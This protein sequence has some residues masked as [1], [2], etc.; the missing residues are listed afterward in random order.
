MAPSPTRRRTTP[1]LRSPRPHR[2]PGEKPSLRSPPRSHPPPDRRYTEEGTRSSTR[3]QGPRSRWSPLSALRGAAKYTKERRTRFP[4]VLRGASLLRDFAR[5]EEVG[6]ARPMGTR[7]LPGIAFDP[8]GLMAAGDVL[9]RTGAGHLYCTATAAIP[10]SSRQ[11]TVGGGSRPWPVCCGIG[12]RTLPEVVPRLSLVRGRPGPGTT[13]TLRVPR[14]RGGSGR[15]PSWTRRRR[16]SR[17]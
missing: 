1:L 14:A 13:G 5:K 10:G 17:R 16:C 3:P 7:R 2:L 9:Y 11:A 4:V 8:V 15:A 12:R 6:S